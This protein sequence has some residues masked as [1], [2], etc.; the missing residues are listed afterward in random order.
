MRIRNLSTLPVPRA[1]WH[2][3]ATIMRVGAKLPGA[4]ANEMVMYGRCPSL[5]ISVRPRRYYPP[6]KI[7]NIGTY[8]YGRI[9]LF[10]CRSCTLGIMTQVLLHELAHA[11]MHQYHDDF[12][13]YHPSCDL[14]ER[15]ANAGFAVL[16]GTFLRPD[17]CRS[18]RLVTR[19]A[20]KNLAAFRAVAN[21]LINTRSSKV[22]EWQPR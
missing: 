12:Y 17:A 16:G 3:L 7:A 5:Q 9:S 13:T 20:M 15:F 8:T 6:D 19:C 11:W 21:S 22:L 18:Y 4:T 14:A 10:P 2:E 1:L